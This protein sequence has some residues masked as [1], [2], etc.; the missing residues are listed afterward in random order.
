VRRADNL[1]TFMYR[2]SWKSGSLNLLETSGL[3]QACNGIALSFTSAY[4]DIFYLLM[5]C[6][7]CAG[8]DILPDPHTQC[9]ITCEYLVI[10]EILVLHFSFRSNKEF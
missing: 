8:R 1:T 3:V 6:Y 4:R 9:L 10:V 2:L 7:V 5:G